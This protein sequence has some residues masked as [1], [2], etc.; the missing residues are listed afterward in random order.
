[1]SI[2]WGI[3][4]AYTAATRPQINTHPWLSG[5]TYGAIVWV[6]MQFVLMLGEVFPPITPMSFLIGIIADVV[7]FGIPVALMIRARG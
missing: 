2:L 5:V 7:F 4:Y 3:G 6:L 1:M